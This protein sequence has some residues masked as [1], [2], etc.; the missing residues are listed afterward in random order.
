MNQFELNGHFV[1]LTSEDLLCLEG[2]ASWVVTAS[3]VFGRIFGEIAKI[4][5][6]SGDNGQWMA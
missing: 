2:G 4:Q 6:Y 1:D 5:L 3:Y